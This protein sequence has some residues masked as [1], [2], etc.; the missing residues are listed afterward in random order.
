MNKFFLTTPIYYVNA[1]PHIG[2]AY[3]T[4]IADAL[5]RYH[6]MRGED[7][8]FLT[9]TDEHSQKNAE[10]AEKAGEAVQ[11]YVDR[12]SAVWQ[13]TFDGLEITNDDFIRT[14]EERHK[15][16]VKKF[17]QVVKERDADNIYLGTYKGWYCVGCEAFKTETELEDGACPIH[18]KPA[19]QIEEK[20][21]FFRL[22]KYREAL[23]NHIEAHPEFVQPES[24]RSEIKSYIK[25]FM[26]DVSITRQSVKWGIPVPDDQSQVIYVWF[27]ALIN[28]LTAAGYGNDEEKFQRYWPA[29]VH[30]V[31]KD[32]IKFHCALWPAMLMA[33][34]LPL[35]R[36][37]FAH[38]Y[39]TVNGEKM[40]KSLGNV[41][42][43]QD[44]V[45][46]Y[47]LDTLRY[48]LLRDIP[49]GE[50]GDF[51]F[52]RLA[53]RYEGELANEL[54][55][56]VHRVL[57]MTEKYFDNRTP[58]VVTGK[59]TAWEAYDQAMENLHPHEAI[60]A[61]W[62][63]VREANKFVDDEA[64]WK[65]AKNNPARLEEVIYILLEML[66]HIAWMLY[67]LLP[68]TSEKILS[69]LGI[70]DQTGHLTYEEAK[71]W[72]GLKAGTKIQKG[73]PLF[74]KKLTNSKDK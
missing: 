66:R 12:V 21:Y 31:G 70:G 17:W 62:S 14:S 23:L 68:D 26:T 49:F 25:D 72:G 60:A 53:A 67:P 35:P 56:L 10:A 63:V 46:D 58:K 19:S 3:T 50:D 43:P 37:V 52:E 20:N 59:I 15:V 54:G 27:D 9:G 28:Y 30:L 33:A 32:I 38:G 16:A 24:R 5:A 69:A 44:I 45:K 48:Y 41:V 64:P 36:Q 73:E 22:T 57:S 18:K 4:I 8:F 13:T 65:L 39:F 6:R 1:K 40:S 55:N 7:T 2:H 11:A 34:G 74:P 71:K 47:D 42:D 51:S 29:D 61:V